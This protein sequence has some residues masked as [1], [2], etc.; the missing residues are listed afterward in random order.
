MPDITMCPGQDCP[1]RNDCYRFRGVIEG[2]FDAFGRAPYD[3]L[4]G[5]CDS[6]W[7][8][9]RLRPSEPQIRDRAYFTWVAAGRPPGQADVHW[10]AAR[11]E[12]ERQAAAL[13]RPL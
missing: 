10:R 6:F 3:P 1:L 2:R 11:D 8:I 12:L 9:A 7:D 4:K 5:T 13:L